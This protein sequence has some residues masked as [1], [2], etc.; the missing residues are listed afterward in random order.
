MDGCS[1]E[2]ETS[3]LSLEEAPAAGLEGNQCSARQ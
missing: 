3:V 2:S 1:S